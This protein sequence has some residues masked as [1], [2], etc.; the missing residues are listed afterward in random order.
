MARILGG[1]VAPEAVGAMLMLMRYRTE[2]A[3]EVAGFVRAMRAG[4]GAWAGLPIGLD[5]PSYASGRS[6]GASWF[7]AA[8]ALVARAGV[9]VLM[10]GRNTALGGQGPEATVRALG[11]PVVA[12]A[13][14]AAQALGSSG[15]A[16]APLDAIDPRLRR[17]LDLRDVLGLRSPVNTCLRALNPGAAPASV[18]GVFHP[19]YRA[20]QRDA[21]V[22]LGQGNLLVIKGGGGEVE[23]HPGKA[24]EL[25]TLRDSRP[26]DDVAPPLGDFDPRRLGD[27]GPDLAHLLAVWR[28]EAEDAFA[29][30]IVV[31]TAALALLAA[32][33]TDGLA[34]AEGLAATL[35]DTRLTR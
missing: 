27:G 6:R 32:R 33:Q 5:W 23:R 35:W 9:P 20:L 31:G 25:C 22:L 19:A 34:A 3:A 16:Y 29:R 8:A 11:L 2:S 13:A 10:H 30:A 7:V 24:V 26:V 12:T 14:E 21:A 1:T 17:L 18:Q 15:F 28:G 4:L